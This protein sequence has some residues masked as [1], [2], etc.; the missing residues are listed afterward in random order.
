M[1]IVERFLALMKQYEI[2][3]G[4]G[5]PWNAKTEWPIEAVENKLFTGKSPDGK[6]FINIPIT[7][8]TFS[9]TDCYNFEHDTFVIF[10]RHFNNEEFFVPIDPNL[11]EIN[12]DLI[13]GKYYNDLSYLERLL[14]GET[15]EFALYWDLYKNS[16]CRTTIR[17]P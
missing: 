12:V 17:R 15:L 7:V 13:V 16:F 3:E 6:L 14:S 9:P 11:F 4:D 10:Q 1:S 5:L 8:E 2:P